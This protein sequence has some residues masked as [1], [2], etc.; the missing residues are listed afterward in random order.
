MTQPSVISG[1]RS[2]RALLAVPSIGRVLLG[3]QIA[4]IAGSMVAVAMV[5]FSLA[6]YHSA[7]L[8]GL[9]TFVSIFPGLLV[10]PIAGAL[11]DRHGR[12]RLVILD[13]VIA[14]ASLVLI[15]LLAL[16]DLLPAWLLVLIAAVSSLTG[17]LSATGL[18][19][20]FPLL[21][22]RHLWERANA[23]DSNGYVLA[24]VVGPPVAGVLVQVW[25][26][27]PALLV[28]GGLHWLA[29]LVLVGSPDPRTETDSTGRLWLDAWRGL[30]YTW[31]NRTLRALGFSISLLNLSSGMTTIVVPLL[32]LDHLHAGAV[33]V[34][35]LFAIQGIFG[36]LAAFVSG[37]FDSEGRERRMLAPPMVGCALAVSLLLLGTGWLPALGLLPL[38]LAMAITGLLNGPMDIALFT[39]RQRRT[40]QAWM[41]RAFAV[42]MSF[43]FMGFPV[44]SALTGWL[45]G[46]SLELAVVFGVAACLGA[47][48]IAQL[49]IPTEA[50]PA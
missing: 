14:G 47:A 3:M 9:V 13:Y 48:L 1:D 49:A 36:V 20:L 2:Y 22:P 41:G 7:P 25:G 37:R 16:A 39:L 10:S 29:G 50:P 28:M 21:V 4:R 6:T 24:S 42:S 5:L 23:V 35:V 30:V 27:P 17:P 8:A 19:S 45:V 26:G 15:G 44:G 40:D 11:L 33:M 46:R 38:A 43:N 34:G 32:V 31:Q 12:T 18:R